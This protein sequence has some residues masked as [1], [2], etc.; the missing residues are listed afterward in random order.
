MVQHSPTD[1]FKFGSFILIIVLGL[2]VI[3]LTY[4][5]DR[6]KQITRATNGNCKIWRKQAKI[7]KYANQLLI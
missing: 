3:S 6:Q 2:I 1:Q 5:T 4:W 7:I